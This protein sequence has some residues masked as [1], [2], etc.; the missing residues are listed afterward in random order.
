MVRSGRVT[1]TSL[2]G[3]VAQ[4]QVMLEY[5]GGSGACTYMEERPGSSPLALGVCLG[6][7]VPPMDPSTHMASLL[8]NTLPVSSIILFGAIIHVS[9]DVPSSHYHSSDCLDFCLSL[10]KE[11]G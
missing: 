4:D 5:G 8:L 3:Q 7:L 1:W 11:P 2:V 10:L 6:S 9:G